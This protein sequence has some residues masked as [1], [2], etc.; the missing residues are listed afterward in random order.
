L[1]VLYVLEIEKKNQP[2]TPPRMFTVM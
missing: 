2:W 1:T